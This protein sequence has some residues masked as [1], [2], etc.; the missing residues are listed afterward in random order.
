MSENDNSLL[1]GLSQRLWDFELNF[2]TLKNH[3]KKI[4]SFKKKSPRVK[5]FVAF[6]ALFPLL[7]VD[8]CLAKI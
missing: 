3:L 6:V 1:Q 4:S 2:A 7:K 8:G 5:R